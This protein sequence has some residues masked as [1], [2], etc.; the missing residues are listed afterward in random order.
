MGNVEGTD[1][2]RD[3]ADVIVTDGFSGNVFLKT[4]EGAVRLALSMVKERF[5]DHA[6]EAQS[7]LGDVLDQLA[8]TLDADAA[9]GALLV[10]T[11]ATVVIAHGSASS[12]AVENAVAMAAD[13]AAHHLPELLAERL[14]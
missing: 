4:T 14:G 9:G 1:V 10:G 6:P 11:N 2:G 8:M 13:G 12:R 5:G 3:A 7:A